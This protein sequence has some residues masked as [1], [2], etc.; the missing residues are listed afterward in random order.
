MNPLTVEPAIL[1]S[2]SVLETI[3]EGRTIYLA[4]T[5]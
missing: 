5:R 3:K 1:E 4:P 2:I